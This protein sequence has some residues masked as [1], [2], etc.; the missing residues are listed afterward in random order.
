MIFSLLSSELEINN[1]FSL[2][3]FKQQHDTGQNLKYLIVYPRVACAATAAAAAAGGKPAAGGGA[4]A[5]PE[6]DVKSPEYIVSA[7]ELETFK[8]IVHSK[9]GSTITSYC[10]SNQCHGCAQLICEAFF[11]FCL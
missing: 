6:L 8:E 7:C 5:E 9:V 1:L 3:T 4:A 10:H 11:F 2:G